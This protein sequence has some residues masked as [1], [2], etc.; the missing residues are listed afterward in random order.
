MEKK[1]EFKSS[2]EIRRARA[3]PTKSPLDLDYRNLLKYSVLVSCHKGR[4]IITGRSV[5]VS[6]L[7]IYH[8]LFISC[9]LT[10]VVYTTMSA[11]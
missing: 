11:Q 7:A 2:S 8:I 9:M 10:R 1:K 6:I 4:R 5:S 3:V